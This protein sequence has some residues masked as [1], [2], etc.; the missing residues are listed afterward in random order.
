MGAL[1]IDAGNYRLKTLARS[2]CELNI[3]RH[4]SR[5]VSE[6]AALSSIIVFTVRKG[7]EV[8]QRQLRVRERVCL[9]YMQT[10]TTRVYVGN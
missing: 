2:A 3:N 9:S 6:H 4:L 5:V 8:A 7:Q 10:Y 1:S